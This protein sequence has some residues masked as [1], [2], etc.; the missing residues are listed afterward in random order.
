[1]KPV[2][3][4]WTKYCPSVD[5]GYAFW[6]RHDLQNKGKAVCALKVTNNGIAI[7]AMAMSLDGHQCLLHSID[8]SHSEW[9][10]KSHIDKRL[11]EL[12]WKLM[13]NNVG[14]MI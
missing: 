3:L 1:M 13:S 8:S 6:K 14:V 5:V 9:M 12:G 11:I 10:A 2:A 7:S 4:P